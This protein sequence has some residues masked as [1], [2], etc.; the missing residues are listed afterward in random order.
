MNSSL[1]FLKKAVSLLL[2]FLL[3]A[4]CVGCAGQSSSLSQEEPVSTEESSVSEESLPSDTSKPEILHGD[5]DELYAALAD[6]AQY[7]VSVVPAPQVGSTGG[8]WAVLGLARSGAEVPEGYFEKYYEYLENYVKECKGVLHERKYTEY[9]RVIVAVTAIGKDARNVAGYDLTKPLGDYEK[10]LFTGLNGPIWALIA[11]DSGEYPMPENPDASVQA[12]RQMYVDRIL[13]C[14]LSDGGW[15]LFGGSKAQSSVEDR[16]DPDI[17]GMALQALAK[18]QDQPA[19]AEAIEGAL[20]CMSEQQNERG[21]YSS[22]GVE[23]SESCVQMIVALC[24][25]GISI[26]DARFVKNGLNMADNLLSYH[27]AGKG[28]LHTQ[29]GTGDSMMSTEQGF[30]GLAALVRAAEGKNSLYRMQDAAV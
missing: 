18:Y 6:T 4:A 16:S 22:W 8:E 1:I 15:S 5:T 2:A 3:A 11:L 19:V 29:D 13:E 12:T 27:Q 25:L 28:F 9:M 23:N 21:G 14:R 20:A 26:E 10:T 17:T 7:L 30:Y 24:E